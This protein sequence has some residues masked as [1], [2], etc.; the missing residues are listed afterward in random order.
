[1]NPLQ[2][3]FNSKV[4]VVDLSASSIEIMTLDEE[5]IRRHL[6]GAAVNAALI[7]EHQAD[8]IV[9]GTG[10]LT[11]SF[12]PASSLMVASFESPTLK[13][14]WHVPFMLRTGPD[15][16]FSGVDY[17]VIKGRAPE[18]CLLYVNH[19]KIQIIPAANIGHIPIPEA[20]KELRKTTPPFQSVILTGP[21]ADLGI[22]FASV[23]IGTNGSLDKAGLA[24]F[25]AGKNLKGILFGGVGGLSFGSM[26][27][28]QGK[29]L[30][31]R[32]AKE[33]NFKK[34]G[35]SSV[36]KT[37]EG[38][39]DAA[40]SAKAIRKK[41]MACYHC[42]SPCMTHVTFSWHDQVGKG[43]DGL[44]L[45]DHAGFVALAGKVGKNILPVLRSCLHHGLDPAAVAAGIPDN[46]TMED[47]LSVL[48]RIMSDDSTRSASPVVKGGC[49][50]RIAT[51]GSWEKRVALALIL[52][53]CPIFLLR[54]TEIS[55]SDLLTFISTD[56]AVATTIHDSL[57]SAVTSLA[58][59]IS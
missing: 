27:P 56:E 46:A 57:F 51:A 28:A 48:A 16:K 53:V 10:P 25:M 35:F 42:P 47:C 5:F 38:G 33:K 26:N 49:I 1:M 12:A 37:I 45:L 22:P 54:I 29:E 15:M 2:T 58:P 44:L 3:F 9:L 41:D 36:L 23:S 30:E 6:G 11:G 13:R 32:I 4:G 59:S 21:A 31:K 14:M 39:K 20:I 8:P 24:S 34:R 17:L 19:G 40:R 50:P 43:T 55:E 7:G 52:G 18:Q